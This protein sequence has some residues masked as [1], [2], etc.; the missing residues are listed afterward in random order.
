MS[1][2][3]TAVLSPNIDAFTQTSKLEV[4]SVLLDYGAQ[5]HTKLQTLVCKV[6]GYHSSDSYS[7][8]PKEVFQSGTEGESYKMVVIPV[9]TTGTNNLEKEMAATK[10]ML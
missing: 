3:A 8:S 10:V 5:S 4:E 7:P 2:A 6:E 9:K 1:R